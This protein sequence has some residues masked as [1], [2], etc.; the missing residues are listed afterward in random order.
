VLLG[1]HIGRFSL[2]SGTNFNRDWMD[3]TPGV[4]A[5]LKRHQSSTG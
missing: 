4:L 5:A 2:S 1:S 3:V